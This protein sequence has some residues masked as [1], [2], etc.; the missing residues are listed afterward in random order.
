MFIKYVDWKAKIKSRFLNM[1]IIHKLVLS[2]LLVI[3][4]SAS[5]FGIWCSTLFRSYLIEGEKKFLNQSVLQL[6]STIDYFFEVYLHK[7]EMMY[8][9]VE[10]QELITKKND[11]LVE[12][13]DTYYGINKIIRQ[14]TD[15]I[16]NPLL[17]GTYYVGGRLKVQLYTMNQSLVSDGQQILL[18]EDIKDELWCKNLYSS[19]KIVTF[20]KGVQD[21]NGET[22]IVV[23]QRLIDF[24]NMQDI[25]I[26]RLHIPIERVKNVIS[27]NLPMDA[28]MVLYMDEEG[29]EIVRAGR[30]DYNISVDEILG[31]IGNEEMYIDEVFIHD[32][33]YVVGKIASKIT[34]WDILYLL[35][36]NTITKKV[37]V[38][39]RI[40]FVVALGCIFLGII[41]AIFISR[42]ITKRINV[43]VEKAN[44]IT[45]SNIQVQ[46]VIE[47][48]DEIGQ[49]DKAFN[50]MMARINTLIENEYTW[51]LKVD[52]IK[53]ELFQERINP[54]MLYNSLA[55]IGS[56]SSS[57]NNEEI[58]RT[59]DNLIKFYKGV[60]N[61]GQI[62][63][64]IR[65]EFDMV[66][67][68]IDIM[69]F[70]YRLDIETYIEIGDEI[71]DFYTIKL[72]L[73]P[74]V[75]NAILHGIKPIGTG[76]IL[77]EGWLEAGVIHI[78]VSDNG[79]GMDS[80]RL[81]Q[82]Q[83]EY[84]NCLYSSRGFGMKNVL[85]RIRLF[86]GNDFGIKVE[87]NPGGGLRIGFTIP[88]LSQELANQLLK[89]S[90]DF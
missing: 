52:K 31:S 61:E 53:F 60:L 24:K 11:N 66:K 84:E 33:C 36:E 62:L 83:L 82:L 69:R 49:L 18:Y 1:K 59:I 20:E 42:S 77:I 75:E 26:L 57:Q 35:P 28:Y 34:D 51:K 50:E 54:H 13:V 21:K 17:E 16:R 55:M 43:L 46:T 87:H 7:M 40:T 32:N 71:E 6:N 65:S 48:N 79:V 67:T 73:Q 9:N 38:F 78:Y 64:T 22:Y 58:P 45:E 12:L 15:D 72:L 90:N 3:C 80:Y 5:V 23:N 8:S 70:V 19:G 2:F 85:E 37:Y 4:V 81:N 29:E 25:G 41:I 76:V 63:T 86:F 44:A 56:L 27:K 88:A 74:I 89:N 10:L 14:I 68:Y 39:A 30:I 47:G